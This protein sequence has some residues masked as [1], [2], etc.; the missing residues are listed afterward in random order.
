[1]VSFTIDASS[2]GF[3]ALLQATTRHAIVVILVASHLLFKQYIFMPVYGQST[4]SKSPNYNL[5]F[6]NYKFPSTFSSFVST[7]LFD[8]FGF[9]SILIFYFSSFPH[10]ISASSFS[11]S[12]LCWLCYHCSEAM[13]LTPILETHA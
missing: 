5:Q 10:L 9:N 8:Y 11:S 1:M 6:F 3:L 7:K 12:F 2:C 4:A 13:A